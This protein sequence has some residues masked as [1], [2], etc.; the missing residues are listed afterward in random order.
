MK[1]LTVPACALL[2]FASCCTPAPATAPKEE[3]ARHSEPAT[4]LKVIPLKH[5][6]ASDVADVVKG[7]LRGVRVV[8]DERTNS[9]LVA[10]QNDVDF[11]QIERC[12]AQLDVE[13]KP[14]AK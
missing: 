14:A 3:P 4:T 9:V 2:A 6:V 11:A 1:T 8:A 10:Y 5:A 12:I 13:V 7:S